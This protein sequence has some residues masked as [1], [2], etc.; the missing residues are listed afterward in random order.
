MRQHAWLFVVVPEF[1]L[2]GALANEQPERLRGV[3]LKKE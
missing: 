1:I 2:L 3:F